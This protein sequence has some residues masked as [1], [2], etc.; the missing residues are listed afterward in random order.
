MTYYKYAERKAEDQI[1]W[2]TISKGIVDSI[3]AEKKVREEKKTQIDKES[4]AIMQEIANSPTTPS[5]D[6]TSFT[7][8]L[9]TQ[10]Q[11]M[12]RT[13]NSE[14]KSGNISL[15]DYTLRKQNLLNNTKQTYSMISNWGKIV[16]T[17]M[18]R[19]NNGLESNVG[20]AAKALVEEAG[21]FSKYAPY[22]GVD[23][24][25]KIGPKELSA[26]NAPSRMFDV[27]SLYE[28][29]NQNVDKVDFKASIKSMADAVENTTMK[30]ASE[31][32]I[33]GQ[34]V[35]EII[36]RTK[37][38]D[39]YKK[40]ISTVVSGITNNP[41]TSA[42]YLMD[43]LPA[44]DGAWKATFDKTLAQSNPEQYVYY[45]KGANGVMP[46]LMDSQKKRVEDAIMS[47]VDTMIGTSTAK[48]TSKQPGFYEKVAASQT[49]GGTKAE[50]ASERKAREDAEASFLNR[51]QR[52]WLIETIKQK[53]PQ[54]MI[55]SE[56]AGSSGRTAIVKYDDTSGQYVFDVEALNK[57]SDPDLMYWVNTIQ[58]NYIKKR[59]PDPFPQEQWVKDAQGRAARLSRGASRIEGKK[60]SNKIIEGGF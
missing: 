38:T 44:K 12:M 26:E 1:D 52:S 25:I 11:D 57:L 46:I 54:T 35:S 48:E 31:N 41:V 5:G 40:Y 43:E 9:S 42:K 20:I 22:I 36:D 59:Q 53:V 10:A 47:T 18:D 30:I 50:T 19:I 56:L 32:G 45:E 24:T 34:S 4:S 8:N 7:V 15:S 3:Q 23:G 49:T 2:G 14:L 37:S 55:A 51:G 21:D 6:L 28:S 39:S 16:S 17:N 13:L 33:T 58:A 60:T 29:L 27:K